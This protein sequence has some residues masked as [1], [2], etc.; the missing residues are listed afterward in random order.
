VA[1]RGVEQRLSAGEG[2]LLLGA[3]FALAASM[4]L[5]VAL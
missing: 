3:L 2:A 5:L 1:A 4:A